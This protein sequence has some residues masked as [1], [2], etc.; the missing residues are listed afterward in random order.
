MVFKNDVHDASRFF[1][2]WMGGPMIVGAIAPSGAALSTLVAQQV[3]PASHGPILELGPGTGACPWYGL[4][5]R[6][7]AFGYTAI[8]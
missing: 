8:S 6:Q 3:D 2:A 5:F 4:I 7:P 1:K